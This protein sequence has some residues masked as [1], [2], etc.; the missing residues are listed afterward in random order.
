MSGR[1]L[2]VS[3]CVLLLSVIVAGGMTLMAKP[4]G[5]KGWTKCPVPSCM[6]PCIPDQG[7]KILCKGPGGQRFETTWACC[8]CGSASGYSWRPL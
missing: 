1:L 6:A 7:T 4:D 2:R 3:V 8:C 5:K